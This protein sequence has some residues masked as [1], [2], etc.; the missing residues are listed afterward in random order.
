MT[1]QLQRLNP[2]ENP[3]EHDEL[4]AK[5]LDLQRQKRELNEMREGDE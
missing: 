4:F 2:L 1:P 3:K 5:L